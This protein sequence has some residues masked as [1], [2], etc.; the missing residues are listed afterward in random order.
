MELFGFFLILTQ[1]DE[2]I[3]AYDKAIEINPQ[4]SEDPSLCSH[5]GVFLLKL[6]TNP[7]TSST[8]EL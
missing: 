8:V 4:S 1:F 3:K 6:A 2:A 7:E 5:S